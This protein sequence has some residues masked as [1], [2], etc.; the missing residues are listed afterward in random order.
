MKLVGKKIVRKNSTTVDSKSEIAVNPVNGNIKL[1]R[2]LISN[3]DL[4]G[5]SIGFAYPETDDAQEVYLYE[6]EDGIAVNEN[7]T[8]SSRYHAREL[9]AFFN[10]SKE[11]KF[12]IEVSDSVTTIDDHEDTNFYRLFGTWTS[13]AN[14]TTETH[15]EME[16]EEV[17][18]EEVSEE[19]EA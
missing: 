17:E 15:T 16:S 6:D 8:F 18:F 13:E 3:L 1:S 4:E 9:N 12:K 5:K 14:T 11:E 7:G 19:I 2:K 10:E